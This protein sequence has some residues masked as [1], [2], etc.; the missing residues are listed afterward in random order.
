MIYIEVIW[1]V[2]KANV[3]AVLIGLGGLIC[4]I[5]IFIPKNSKIYKII[6]WFKKK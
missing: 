1:E 5:S 6:D 3:I 2:I 4:T